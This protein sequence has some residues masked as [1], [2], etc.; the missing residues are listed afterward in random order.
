MI[1]TQN[2]TSGPDFILASL[3]AAYPEKSFGENVEVLLEDKSVGTPVLREKLRV[4][5]SDH[6]ELDELRSE[7]IDLFDRGKQ[8]NSLYETEYGRERALVKGNELVDISG[9]YH[10]FGFEM[11]G[12]GVQAEMIDHVAVELEFYALLL[13]KSELLNESSDSDGV[14][15]VLDARKKFLKSHLGRFI[16]AIC[17][18][19]GVMDSSFYSTVFQYCKDVV[20][21]E[22]DRLGVEV[23][24]ESWISGQPEVSEITCGGTVGCVK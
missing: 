5:L 22:C 4:L 17:E 2:K 12:D 6:K 1:A 18:R 7:Y 9:F 13:L 21:A 3:L 15:I 16:G 23:E 20:S 19:P 10:A 14:E 24:P 11:G 8:V